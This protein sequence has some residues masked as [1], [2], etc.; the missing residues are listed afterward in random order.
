MIEIKIEY[1][2][3]INYSLVNNRIGTCQSLEVRNKGNASLRD[4]VIVCEGEFFNTTRSAA[5]DVIKARSAVRLQGFDLQPNP[6]R[7]ASITEKTLTTFRLKV[8]AKE[9]G[10]EATEMHSQDFQID[11]MPY[12]QWL[13]TSILPQCIASFVT[14]NHPSINNVIIKAAQ[15]LKELSN[16]SQFTE[17]QTGNTTEVRKQVAAVYGALHG[18]NIVYRSMPASYEEVGQTR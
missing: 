3:A 6:E 5:I 15:T 4:V 9:N 1:L 12:D 11:V 17:Y 18:E 13:G 14:P 7:V 16:S 2:P 10:G 8:I